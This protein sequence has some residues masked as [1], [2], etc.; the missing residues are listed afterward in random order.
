MKAPREADVLKAVLTY[1]RVVRRW[2]AER[3]NAG[4]GLRNG[5]PVR[6]GEAGAADL[7]GT[8]PPPLA[9]GRRLEVEV[10]RPGGKLRPAQAAWLEMMRATGALCLV[11]DSV[12]SL[13][14]QLREAGY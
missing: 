2:H 11:V 4:G 1:L 3:R 13:E 9:Q 8:I 7:S 10:K 12:E 6:A 14:R 5:R